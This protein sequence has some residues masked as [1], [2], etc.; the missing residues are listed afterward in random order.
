[1][2]LTE[3]NIALFALGISLI[4]LVWQIWSSAINS[5]QTK[6]ANERA[7]KASI[8]ANETS[9]NLLDLEKRVFDTEERKGEIVLIFT[10]H[11]YFMA[12]YNLFENKIPNKPSIKNNAIVQK[13]FIKEC[14]SI[15]ED[16]KELINN[17]AY[18]K[19]LEK[20]PHINKN[21]VGLSF[22]IVDMEY[23]IE[24]SKE[25]QINYYTYFVF[26]DLFFLL[27]NEYKDNALFK[28]DIINDIEK[29][30]E[31]IKIERPDNI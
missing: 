22:D 11:R 29:S 2:K 1:M 17:P 24:K 6:A 31:I 16:L 15:E 25:F 10:I 20:Y 30:F 28:S 8:E 9:K 26:K 12:F 7:I 23:R 14:K 4:T 18:I 19:L 21:R 27:K 13:Q 3:I 5:K